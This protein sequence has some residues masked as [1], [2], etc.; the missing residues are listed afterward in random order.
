MERTGVKDLPGKVGEKVCIKGWVDA[1]REHG[2]VSFLEIRDIGGTVQ[3]VVTAGNVE[4]FAKLSDV[5]KEACVEVI[6]EVKIRPE[7]TENKKSVA[8]GV[9]IKIDEL[10]ILNTCPALP[11]D[12]KNENT[13]EDI[14][15]KYRYLDLRRPE[16]QKPLLLRGQIIQKIRE[17]LYS[18]GFTEF[19][20]PILAK[21]TPEGARDYIVPAR[22]QPGKFYALPQSPQL[23]KQLLMVGG[24]EKYFQIARCF[25]DEDL[26]SDRQ[27]E[28]TQLDAEMSFANEEDIYSVVEGTLKHV[29]KEV[30]DVDVKIP[31]GRIPYKES[32]DK[33]KSDKPDL[34]EET[35]EEYAFTWITNFPLFNYSEEEKRYVAAHHPFCMP[36]NIGD[37]DKDPLSVL[38]KTYDLVLNGT[39]LLSGSVR[40]HIPEI[41]RKVFDLLQISRE[42]QDE[43]FG[44]FLD[45]FKYGAPPHAGFAIGLDRLVQK[46]VGAD[47]IREV[48]AFPKNKEAKDLMLNAPSNI[49]EQQL[50]DVH[51]KLD[52]PKK[53]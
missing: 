47:S 7:G 39:E 12:L 1:V 51:I 16:L 27:P 20:T 15:L 4:S 43:K 25:R 40:I 28:F 50:K 30:F 26:R 44:F 13:N 48:I 53:E 11:F 34:R 14:R 37:L 45:S 46:F 5:S 41:Q 32:M 8:G 33:Y 22:R 52:L 42:E 24:L 10:N 19:E 9:E 49:S 23:F 29:L 35:G 6:G 3:T 36:Q 38:G 2:K 18:R 17:Y 21:S 31:F